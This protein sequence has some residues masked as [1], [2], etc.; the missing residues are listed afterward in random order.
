M[1]VSCNLRYNI[2][3]IWF[4]PVG[5]GGYL[6]NG[7]GDPGFWVPW[8]DDYPLKIRLFLVLTLLPKSGILLL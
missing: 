1:D 2:V 6:G 4:I 5:S 3:N 8:T 7:M